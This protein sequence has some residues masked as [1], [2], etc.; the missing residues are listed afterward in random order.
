MAKLNIL[1]AQRVKALVEFLN[2]QKK[3]EIRDLHDS[4]MSDEEARAIVDE[5][6]GVSDARR[7]V[8]EMKRV[9]ELLSAEMERKIGTTCEVVT[10]RNYMNENA[11]KYRE[12]F[13]EVKRGDIDD[14]ISEVKQKYKDKERSLWLC[15]TLE[16][17]KEIVGI[18]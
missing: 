9:S 4:M 18:Q 8:E 11:D 1:G 17:A 14:R 12:R 6:F 10:R 16:D 15:E 13:N 2:D 5:E 3:E 7:E